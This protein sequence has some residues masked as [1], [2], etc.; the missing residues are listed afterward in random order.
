MQRVFIKCSGGSIL[1]ILWK[2]PAGRWQ[3]EH[4]TEHIWPM[5]QTLDMPDLGGCCGRSSTI[6]KSKNPYM[7]SMAL[8]MNLLS[9]RLPTS[10][11]SLLLMCPNHLKPS[12]PSVSLQNIYHVLFSLMASFLIL[13]IFIT[14]KHNVN[15]FISIISSSASYL[16][17]RVCFGGVTH[18]T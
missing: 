2:G 7:S 11:P 16:Y 18:H 9:V 8:S 12:L 1:L 10:S 3:I 14:P 5:H 17:L 15:I 13:L 6:I 4:R